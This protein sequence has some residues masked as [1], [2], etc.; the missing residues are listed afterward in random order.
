MSERGHVPFRILVSPTGQ[1]ISCKAFSSSA[2][3]RH[4]A[5]KALMKRARFHPA[6]GRDGKPY[7]G[8]FNYIMRFAIAGTRRTA[9]PDQADVVLTVAQLPEGLKNPAYVHLTFLVKADGGVDGCAADDLDP[10][11]QLGEIACEQALAVHRPTVQK[12]ENDQPVDAVDRMRVR[13]QLPPE[14]PSQD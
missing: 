3:F 12:D 9:R 6:T 1:P 2:E 7:H 4:T 11:T 5:C 13:F 14:K 8:V 10:G